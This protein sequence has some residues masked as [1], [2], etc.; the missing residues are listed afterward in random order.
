MK[1]EDL[2]GVG[3]K[4]AKE[5]KRLGIEPTA[6]LTADFPRAYLAMTNRVSVFSV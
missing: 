6:Q 2:T 5:F 4:R 3:K 1:L